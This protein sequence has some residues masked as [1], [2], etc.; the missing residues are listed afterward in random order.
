MD[1]DRLERLLRETMQHKADDVRPDELRPMPA[2]L[3]EPV[4][5]APATRHRRGPIL[6]LS[7][8]SAVA[9]AAA[10]VFAWSSHDPDP[11]QVA[12]NP[13]QM[14]TTTRAIAPGE[15]SS[16][17]SSNSPSTRTS[18]MT[19]PNDVTS[20]APQTTN[21]TPSESSTEPSPQTTSDDESGSAT[22]ESSQPASSSTES[23]TS[24]EGGDKRAAGRRGGIDGESTSSDSG[25]DS[26]SSSTDGSESTSSAA[27]AEPHL[28]LTASPSSPN[29]IAIAMKAW[30]TQHDVA[31][32]DGGPADLSK[33]V[34]YTITVVRN[35]DGK[36]TTVRSEDTGRSCSTEG[37]SNIVYSSEA[38]VSTVNGQLVSLGLY[39]VRAEA[40]FCGD[41]G[42]RTLTQVQS[43]AVPRGL[44]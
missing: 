29:S 7:A 32:S 43:V 37:T 18:Y 26:Q 23:T 40:T 24:Q 13:A 11:G 27:A 22:D 6:V 17:S 39:T 31:A 14:T 8:G 25:S 35:E 38:D 41:D 5:A 15:P 19:E 3:A 28:S 1:Q 21:P 16:T 10:A 44:G 42:E 34:S 9:A 2:E 20:L 12:A 36:A 30:G 33:P 4:K